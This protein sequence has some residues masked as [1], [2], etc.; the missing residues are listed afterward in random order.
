MNRL[1]CPRLN[2]TPEVETCL[3]SLTNVLAAVRIE[4]RLES[5]FLIEA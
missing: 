3:E 4:I 2:A 1:W 5:P